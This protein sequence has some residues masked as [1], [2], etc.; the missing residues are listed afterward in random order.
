MTHSKQ[1]FHLLFTQLWESFSFF[2]MRVL[3]VLY[4]IKELNYSSE[5]AIALYVLYIALVEAGSFVG[6]YIA[7]N[8]L[9]L[10]R[11]IFWGGIFITLGHICLIFDSS[12]F[13]GLGLI[14]TG[15]A[16]FRSNL[17]T[18]LGH[19]YS[20]EEGRNS[21]YTLLY[22]SINLGGFAAALICSIVAEL[23]G[24][25]LGFGLAMIGMIIGMTFFQPHIKPKKIPLR[26]N[27]FLIPAPL[28]FAFL[29][30]HAPIANLFILPLSIIAFI[31][32]LFYLKASFHLCIVIALLIIYFS[33][34]ELA[35][36][37][38]ILYSETEINRNLFGIR[39]PAATLSTINPLIIIL[40]GPILSRY[41]ISLRTRI[42]ISFINL[43][44]AFLILYTSTQIRNPTLPYLFIPFTIIGLGELLLAPAI[45]TLCS[46]TGTS[47][48]LV[49][50]AFSLANL[51][52]G[53]LANLPISKGALF[54]AIAITSGLLAFFFKSFNRD[55]FL[56]LRNSVE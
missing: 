28:I 6:G 37:L 14:I 4:L 7:D 41:H 21:G 10:E 51:F 16:L 53:H 44:V 50:I 17:K 49:T 2:G 15:S 3:L 56:T 18:L 46:K 38:L 48:G 40:T 5:N 23:Y 9:G 54:L 31:F 19:L 52:S 27:I 8:Y 35:G 26:C 45:F 33:I 32:I 13:I 42:M 29:L 30:S 47:M 1:A 39:L 24:W 55:A 22:S 11:A 25:H 34:S 12:F 43:S 36:S 20:D